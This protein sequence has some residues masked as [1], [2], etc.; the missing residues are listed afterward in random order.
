GEVTITRYETKAVQDE[1]YDAMLRF[2]DDNPMYALRFL[3][4][5]ADKFSDSKR[6]EIRAHI[7]KEIDSVGKEYLS[8]QAFDAEYVTYDEPSD[9]NGYTI[10]NID[11]IEAIVSYF[12]KKVENLFKVKLM[13]MLWYADVLFYKQSGHSMTGMVYQHE[14]MGALPIGHYKL[15]AL[16]NVDVRE[17]MSRSFDVILHIY[18]IQGMDYTIL[19]PEEKNVLDKVIDKFKPFSTKEIVEYMHREKAYT[20]TNPGEIIPFSLASE[21]RDF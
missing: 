16:E 1:A 20:D 6:A 2:V 8:R 3:E 17:E 13:K 15:M 12:A 10:L 18:P 11:K 5:H 7:M 14:A 4:K 19:S 21:I 9:S